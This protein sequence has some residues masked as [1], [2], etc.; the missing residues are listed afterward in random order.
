MKTRIENGHHHL[1]ELPPTTLPDNLSSS[2]SNFIELSYEEGNCSHGIFKFILADLKVSYRTW[3]P[4]KRVL[5]GQIWNDLTNKIH[6]VR[7]N[8]NL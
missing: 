6:T 5:N 7:W 4:P 2:G 1:V 3:E 8:Y